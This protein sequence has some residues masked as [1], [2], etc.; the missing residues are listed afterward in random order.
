MYQPS[1]A[2]QLLFF[3]VH[4]SHDASLGRRYVPF[5]HVWGA[6][7]TEDFIF[8]KEMFHFPIAATGLVQR[9]RSL[10]DGDTKLLTGQ[11]LPQ[12]LL[13]GRTNHQT[14]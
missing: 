5:S 10:Y 4:S 12:P 9:I 3:D 14:E 1:I 7:L 13:P 6:S 8:R 2:F 11:R